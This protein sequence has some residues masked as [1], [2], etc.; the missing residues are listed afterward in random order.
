M[1]KINDIGIVGA[2]PAGITAAIQLKRSSFEPILFEKN[3]IGGLLLNANFVENYP[4]FPNGISG[5]E[6]VRDF[7]GHLEKLNIKVINKGIKKINLKED[8]FE[9]STLNDNFYFHTV[10]VAIGTIP[11]KIDIPG[12][13]KLFRKKLFYE[14][15]NLPLLKGDESFVIIGGG[16]AAYDYTLNLAERGIHSKILYRNKKLKCLPLL[17]KRVKENSK[18]ETYPETRVLS[19]REENKNVNTRYEFNGIK[20]SIIS[21]YVLVAIGRKPDYSILPE[22]V[23]P[24][25]GENGRAE[26]PGLYLIGDVCGGYRQVGIAVGNALSTAMDINDYLDIVD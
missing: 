9:L 8:Y 25:I 12:A 17:V 22:S 19:F 16:D 11:N 26:I 6:L 15:K 23:K 5:K 21:S 24:K 4:G 3:E 14:I 13:K 1:E 18:I 2:G 10:V 20:K 7:K